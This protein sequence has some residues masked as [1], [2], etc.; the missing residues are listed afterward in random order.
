MKYN[1]LQQDAINSLAPK[2]LVTA[3]AGSGKTSTLVGAIQKYAEDN[4]GDRIVAITFTKK[5]ALELQSRTFGIKVDS[6]T[7]HSWSLKELNRLGTKYKFKV[8]ILQDDQI[9][10]ILQALSRK[11]GYYSMNY[12]MLFAYVMGN[13]N[14]DVAQSTKMKYEKVLRTY[15]QYKRE[16]QLY[17]FTDLP[18]YLYDMLN[19]YNEEI[20]SIDG[21]FVDEFQ[22]VDD[23]QAKIFTKVRAKKY[24]YIGDA[25]QSIYI[26]RSAGPQNLRNLTDF[27]HHTLN[28]NYRS[29]QGIIDYANTMRVG[30]QF[31]SDTIKTKP[32]NIICAR[33]DED[34]EVYVVED[35]CYCHDAIHGY[36]KD[37]YQTLTAFLL[38]KPYILC[39]S[40]KQVKAIES[41]GYKNVSTI[42]QAKGLEYTNVIVT[43]MELNGEEEINIAYVA[44]TRAQNGLLICDS[45]T[46][47]MMMNEILY[48]YRD[49][50]CGGKLF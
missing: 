50:I 40:N 11:C 36:I 49:E 38:K 23:V 1:D 22:D 48:E 4:P 21:L 18:L 43:D 37:T 45:D 39:R 33:T 31:I 25:Q 15:I 35:E 26:F 29:Y 19:K 24:F 44:C 30:N 46:L 34:G 12:F 20:E 14:I 16:N 7:I 17:D 5:A 9:Q 28:I 27:E 42:H 32:C 8:S 10:E 47:Y 41:L 6:S 2:V 3:P 13:Y